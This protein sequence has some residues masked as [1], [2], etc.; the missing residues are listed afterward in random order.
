VTPSPDFPQ[1]ANDFALRELMKYLLTCLLVS[2]AMFATQSRQTFSGTI[3]DDGCSTADHSRMRMGSTDTA[4]AIACAEVH[5]GQFVL[6][7][8]KEIYQLSDQGKSKEFAGK[9]VTVVGTLDSKTRTI[10]VNS[11]AAAK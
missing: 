3:T 5:G 1:V 7:D 10:Q 6:F 4:C 9:K 8:G 11:M 2:A